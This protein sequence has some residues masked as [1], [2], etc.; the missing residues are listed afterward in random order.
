MVSI[1]K[2]RGDLH[3]A[4]R[5]QQMRGLSW[6]PRLRRGAEG[7]ASRQSD[8]GGI[9]GSAGTAG[10]QQTIYHPWELA[11]LKNHTACQ[12]NDA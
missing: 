1:T 12:P 6:T 7:G 8:A 4:E 10:V 11:S 2:L 3:S 9:G 5:D